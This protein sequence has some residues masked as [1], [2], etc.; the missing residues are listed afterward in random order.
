MTL[1]KQSIFSFFVCISIVNTIMV[2]IKMIRNSCLFILDHWWYNHAGIKKDNW[3]EGN[4]QGSALYTQPKRLRK[5][6]LRGYDKRS[7]T[8][9]DF[10]ISQ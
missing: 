5:L 6:C 2:R 3:F 9:K 8:F 7:K 4:T 10:W 1:N